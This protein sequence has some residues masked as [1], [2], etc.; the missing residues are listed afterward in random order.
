MNGI[1]DIEKSWGS[2]KNAILKGN[3]KADFLKWWGLDDIK[4]RLVNKEWQCWTT[5]KSY[6]L[7]C[8]H[9]YPT[10]YKELEILLVT[11]SGME[12]WN[13]LAWHMLKRFANFH[14]C[15]EIDFTGRPGWLKYGKRHEPELKHEYRYRVM[16]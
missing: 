14:G 11:G 15:N 6:F 2:I 10:G 16:L 8:I 3:N 7:T 1:L 4:E 9:K 5:G 13:N 12:E